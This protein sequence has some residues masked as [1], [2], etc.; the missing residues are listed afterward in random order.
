MT[1][2]IFACTLSYTTMEK[3]EKM[4]LFFLAL[5]LFLFLRLSRT[6]IYTYLDLCVQTLPVGLCVPTLCFYAR[7]FLMSCLE[8]CPLLKA[9]K[10]KFFFNIFC[11]A[12][13]MLLKLQLKVMFLRPSLAPMKSLTRFRN[14]ITIK[15]III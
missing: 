14:P 1:Y 13:A 15:N 10:K 5:A 9:K 2:E 6:H 12:H 4:S 11:F 7:H 3:M 8:Q